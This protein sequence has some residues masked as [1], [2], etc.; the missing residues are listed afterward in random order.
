[1]CVQRSI[2]PE[3][4]ENYE[5]GEYEESVSYDPEE[6]YNKYL[7]NYRSMLPYQWGVWV[8]AYAMRHLFELGAC[9]YDGDQA[10]W[11]YSDTDS[12]YCHAWDQDALQAYNER[13][14]AKLQAAGYGPV[15]VNGRQFWL[16]IAEFDGHYSQFKALHSK[17]YCKRYSDD[18]RNDEKKRGKLAITVAGVPKS[19]VKCLNDDIHNFRIGTVF[20]GETT[21]KL[22]H[23]YIFVP[24]IYTDERGNETGDSI[25][26]QPCDY[27]LDNSSTVN[28]EAVF[29]EQI[30]LQVY[31]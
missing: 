1:M 10:Y 14:K 27:E 15:D 17:C 13:I 31:E 22:Q 23:Y 26:L 20:D 28:W 18:P 8:T 4:I 2:R 19:G 21:G 11:L 3:L 6:A 5:S 29:T 9:A 25:D 24:D 16:G 12:C 30:Y 7:K